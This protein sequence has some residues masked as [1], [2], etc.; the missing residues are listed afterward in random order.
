MQRVA[1]RKGSS[2]CA[3]GTSRLSPCPLLQ[4]VDSLGSQLADP[5]Q[6]G[7]RR[8]AVRGRGDIRLCGARAL[9]SRIPGANV[10]AFGA[11][12]PFTRDGID[13]RVACV[14]RGQAIAMARRVHKMQRTRVRTQR[15]SSQVC[16]SQEPDAIPCRYLLPTRWK[17]RLSRTWQIVRRTAMTAVAI[18]I[19]LAMRMVVSQAAKP[20]RNGLE[21][22]CCGA[23]MRLQGIDP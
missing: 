5:H 14:C 23:A 17:T 6:Q 22:R 12:L 2:M 16:L 15:L 11:E 4:S 1:L 10:V 7:H 20:R 19:A 9:S 3:P 8:C 13:P 18:E 21:I